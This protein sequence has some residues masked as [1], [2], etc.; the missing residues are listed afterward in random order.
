MAPDKLQ[1]YG[2]GVEGGYTVDAPAIL[3]NNW[4]HIVWAYYGDGSSGVANRLDLWVDGVNYGD[5]R[6]TFSRAIKLNERLLFGTAVARPPAPATA[7]RGP[8]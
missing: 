5:D 6:N 7:F 8:D 4:H 3:D 2:G 1:V